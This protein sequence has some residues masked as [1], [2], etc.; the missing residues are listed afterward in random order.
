MRDLISTAMHRRWCLGLGL[1]S[2]LGPLRASALQ[3]HFSFRLPGGFKAPADV[4]MVEGIVPAEL[5]EDA[6]GQDAFGVM[7]DRGEV[8]AEFVN[9][10]ETAVTFNL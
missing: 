3:V 8:I 4:S 9:A 7:M 6:R 5:L 1:V 10:R 2:L